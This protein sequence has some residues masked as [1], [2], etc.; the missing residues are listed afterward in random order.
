MKKHRTV[1]IKIGG[2]AVETD[3]IEDLCHEIAK[4]A[5]ATQV[6]VVH[7]GGAELTRVSQLFGIQ[8]RFE[9][10]LRMTGPGEMQVVDMVL[11]GKMNKSLV[12]RLIGRGARPVGFCGADG[13]TITGTPVKDSDG[14]PTATGRIERVDTEFLSL[15]LNAGY[16]PV[17]ASA[18]SS[19]DGLP[20]NI[21]ADDVAFAVAGAL[22]ARSLLFFSDI[23]G[24]L[25]QEQVLREV[26]PTE[27]E[28]EIQAGVIAGGMIPKTR[29]AK[30]VLAS[31]VQS[32]VIG[33][34][35]QRGD[36]ERLIANSI[37]TRIHN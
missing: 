21:N 19:A 1:V 11:A 4:L 7:G 15:L 22:Q 32:V 12:R 34:Y 25:K 10:G 29:S 26:T 5:R 27:I 16:L 35:E 14:N 30:A 31:G 28:Q 20:L 17:V 9:N 2:R 37:G 23:P 24:I 13:A 36:L 6:V 8:A 33:R 3:L 18:A